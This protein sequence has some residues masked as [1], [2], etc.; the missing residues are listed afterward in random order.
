[1][2]TLQNI[3]KA[4]TPKEG[5]ILQQLL[6]SPIKRLQVHSDIE[7]TEEEIAEALTKAKSNKQSAIEREQ[8]EKIRREQSDIIFKPFT[9]ESLISFCKVFYQQRFKKEFIIHEQNKATIEKLALYFTGNTDFEIGGYSLNKGILLM[10]NVGVGKTDLMR[11]FQRNKKQCYRVVSCREVA[12][13]YTNYDP[14]DSS[15]TVEKDFATL[16]HTALNDAAYFYQRGIGFCFDDLGTEEIKNNYGNKKNVMADVIMAIYDKK[17]YV[18]FHITTNLD[19]DEIEAMYGTR[20][21]SRLREM[22]NVFILSG[23]DMRA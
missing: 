19:Y 13:S 9:P 20:V 7:L 15:E 23:N 10:G 5:S 21:R 8:R 2:E 14:K 17:S 1:M 3:L 18:P 16:T 11:F 4:V 6:L 12:D 22:F